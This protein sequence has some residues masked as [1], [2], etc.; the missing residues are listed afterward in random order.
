LKDHRDKR[1]A[2]FVVVWRAEFF[3]ESLEK[4]TKEHDVLLLKTE[5]VDKIFGSSL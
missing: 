2:D 3:W 5:R 4:S 1:K